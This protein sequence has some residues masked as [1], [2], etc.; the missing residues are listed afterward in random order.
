MEETMVKTTCFPPITSICR[1]SLQGK[2]ATLGIVAKQFI[3]DDLLG[4][5]VLLRALGF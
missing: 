4:Q 5:G 2:L 3:K 1:P